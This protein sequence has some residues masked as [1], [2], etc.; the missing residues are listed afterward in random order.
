MYD[1]IPIIFCVLTA[2][3]TALSQFVPFFMK[4]PLHSKMLCSALFLLTG[5]SAMIITHSTYSLLM[6]AALFFG[7]LG[8]FWLDYKN[9]K[10]FMTGVLF[11]SI[12]HLIYLYTFILHCQP[13]LWLYRKQ[14]LLGFLALCV[15]AVL[16]VVIDKIR[17]PK[18]RRI[19]ILYS[20][21]LMFSFIFAVSRGTV[22]II[23]GEKEFGL[24][25]VA[26]GGLFL[27]SDTFLAVSLYGKP[28]LKCNDKLVAL[29]Y[30]PAQALFALSI[31]FS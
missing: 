23:N 3:T 1:L 10:Y 5:L 4:K 28:K 20:F 22:S 2:V 29:T 12:G 27:L 21:L 24:C 19:M 26:A 31:L 7:L 9:S 8:D 25:L 11:F 30:F 14:I 18:G 16:E 6:V 17:F 15:A 13:S